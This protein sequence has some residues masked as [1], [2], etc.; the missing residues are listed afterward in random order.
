VAGAVLGINAFDQ[1]NVE[2][3]KRASKQILASGEDV[4]WDAGDPGRLF[5]GIGSGEL[6]VIVAFAPRDDANDEVLAAAR[7]KLLSS[8]GVAT[9]RGFGPRYLHSTGQLQKGG[10]PRVRA[11]VAL[12][13]PAGDEPI[14][15]DRH[16]FARLVSAQALGDVRALRQAGRPVVAA[17]WAD[18]VDWAR[19]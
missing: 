11:A 9:M 10:P 3:A 14:P 5:D 12:D 4:T 8:S 1:P 7:H 18:L 19:S 15:A 2:A 17:T 13:V 16:G 6:A